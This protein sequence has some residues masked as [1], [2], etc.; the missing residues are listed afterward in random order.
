VRNFVWTPCSTTTHYYNTLEE[1]FSPKMNTQFIGFIRACPMVAIKGSFQ[2]I[3]DEVLQS[4][5]VK[6][7]WAGTCAPCYQCSSQTSVKENDYCCFWLVNHND[8]SRWN[9]TFKWSITL[10]LHIFVFKGE[11]AEGINTLPWMCYIWI[12]RL[13]WELTLDML[14]GPNIFCHRM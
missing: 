7:L 12:E 8:T 6:L 3:L 5:S 11:D 13:K 1:K 14:L 9:K 2:Y 10:F 4:N